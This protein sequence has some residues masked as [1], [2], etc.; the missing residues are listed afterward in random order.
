[1]S[2]KPSLNSYR[3]A[4][5]YDSRGFSKVEAGG[6]EPPSEDLQELATTRLFRDLELALRTPTNGLPQSQPI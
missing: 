5:V 3:K 1:V 6:I 2:L 4:K